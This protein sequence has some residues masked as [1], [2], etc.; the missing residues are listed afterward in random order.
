MIQSQTTRDRRAQV[1]A[2][3]GLTFQ[4]VF[5]AVIAL[6][7]YFTKS[8]AILAAARWMLGG[9][10]IWPVL[11]IVYGQRRRVAA[12]RLEVA[13]LKR[14][15][16]AGGAA[17]I[18]D[19]EDEAYLVEKRRLN[20][21][22][23]WLVPG[24]ALT[25]AAYHFLAAFVGWGWS[26][27]DSLQDHTWRVTQNPGP[28]M[29]FVGGVAF[30]AF[31][32]SRYAAGM[33]RV[34]GWRMI[35]A[36]GS[37]LAGNALSC[38]IVLVAIA[39]QKYEVPHAEA[40]ATYAI[41]IAMLVVGIEFIANFALDFYRPRA[42]G[43]E[44]RPAFDS[45]LLAMISEPGGIARSIADAINYQFGFEVSS[46][47]FYQLLKRAIVPM[48][49]FGILCLFAL[50][51]VLIVDADEQAV[52]ERF[53]RRLQAPGEALGPGLYFKAPWPI[54]KA[55]RA[56]VQQVRTLKIGTL[57]NASEDAFEVVDGR[58]RPKP[59]LWGEEHKFN[60]EMMVI[61]ASPELTNYEVTTE[62]GAPV[63]KDDGGRAVAVGLLMVS[64]EIQY[65][66]DDLHGY[67]YTY[68]DPEKV[69]QAIAYQVLSD[70]AAGVDVDR[71]LG[72]GR[73]EINTTLR[74]ILQKRIDEQGLGIKLLFVGV[75]EA[76]PTAEVAKAFQ[77]VVKAEREKRNLIENA[78]GMAETT[79]T[80][81][82]G[83][84][85]RAIQLD[86]AIQE[87]QN[88]ENGPDATQ[89]ALASA[90]KK[91]DD[92]LLGTPDKRIPPA[93]GE[94]AEKIA[95][96]QADALER[97]TEK[98]SEL[99]LFNAELIAYEASPKL[100]RYRKY[101]QMLPEAVEDIRKYVLAVDPR[102]HVIVEYEKEEKGVIDIGEPPSNK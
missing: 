50:S 65:C 4:I 3:V 20:W 68:R 71:F 5:F 90:Q 59:L 8:D 95:E 60:P 100:Y 15:Q 89:E 66:V 69:V 6:L 27:S 73:P 21:V 48:L 36:G 82:A 29:A 26:L 102:V 39:L 13:E 64:V 78:R 43:Q 24:A 2:Y 87:M 45:R 81:T 37:Y 44:T 57:A 61:V 74:R 34:G 35:R 54:D 41:R 56:R 10:I 92:L 75:Q 96:E 9:V 63:A 17:P 84:S 94:A 33:A 76:H 70:Y 79:L 62:E 46:T 52:I 91:V 93:G 98:Q 72:P 42:L 16:E 67:L 83:S 19:T 28:A 97:V 49:A 47:W 31:L 99:T 80:T 22:L 88:L 30:L 86:E 11:A 38:L 58:R 32:F 23:R 40:V 77:E 12:E 18:F 101:L 14:Q 53:G 1:T 85:E 55:Y 25:L 51:S 7:G